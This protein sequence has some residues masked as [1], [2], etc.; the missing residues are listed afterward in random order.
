[1]KRGRPPGGSPDTSD[2]ILAAAAEEFAGHGLAGARTVR[3][4]RSAGVTHAMLH[5][6]FRSKDELYRSVLA[7]LGAEFERAMLEAIRGAAAPMDM[8]ALVVTLFEGLAANR[9]YVRM[10]LWDLAAGGG[11]SRTLPLP[12]LTALDAGLLQRLPAG[13]DL[14]QV[15]T[16]LL[17]ATVIYFFDDPLLERLFEGDRFAANALSERAEHLRRLATVMLAAGAPE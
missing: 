15:L 5:Y 14:R 11:Q 4:A 13:V 16:T 7:S 9:A 8:P 17:G 2:R 10:V 12:T 1:M 6:Y 3:I